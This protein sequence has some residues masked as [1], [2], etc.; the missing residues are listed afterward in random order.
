MRRLIDAA[1]ARSR[2]E[3][4]PRFRVDELARDEE[5]GSI[6]ELN[7]ELGATLV[8]DQLDQ[9][10]RIEVDDQRRWSAT[11]SDTGLA[12]LSRA[13]RPRG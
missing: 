2:C 5:V 13:R 1:G 3:C 8:E 4:G 6:P 7:G 11:T 10:R 12:A 9:R